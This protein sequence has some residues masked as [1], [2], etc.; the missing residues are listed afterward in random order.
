V[1]EAERLLDDAG[2]LARKIAGYPRVGVAHAK[3]EFYGALES[4]FE[5][6]TAAE[7]AGEVACFRDSETRA[8]FRKFVNRKKA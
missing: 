6:A 3:T 4:S 2:R 7:H 8:Q 5:E 1:V